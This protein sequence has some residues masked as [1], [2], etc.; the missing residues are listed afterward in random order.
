MSSKSIGA[1]FHDAAERARS[2][3]PKQDDQ[4]SMYGLYKQVTV[5]ECMTNKPSMFDIAGK[6]KWDAWMK[7]KGMSKDDAGTAYI[8]LVDRVAGVPSSLDAAGQDPAAAAP[9]S[10]APGAAATK[11]STP[12]AELVYTSSSSSPPPPPPPSSPPPASPSNSSAANNEG[13]TNEYGTGVP[14]LD[15]D[16]S[17]HIKTIEPT[18]EH[19]P[20]IAELRESLKKEEIYINNKF[21]CDR[22]CTDDALMRFLVAKGYKMHACSKLLKDAMIW[23][24][25][26]NVD[27]QEEEEGWQERFSKEGETG[28]IYNAGLDRWGRSL[29]VFDNTVQNTKVVDGQMKFLAWQLNLAC[30]TMAVETPLIADKYVVFMHLYDFSLFSA[31]SWAA[32]EETIHMLCNCFPERLGHCIAYNAPAM[33]RTFWNL[34]KGFIDPRTRAKLIFVTGDCSNGSDNDIY[35][36]RVIGDDWRDKCCVDKPLVRKGCSPGYDHDIAWPAFMERVKDLQSRENLISNDPE[37]AKHL[38][39]IEE[40][41]PEKASPRLPSV[42]QE[43]PPKSPFFSPFNW[44]KKKKSTPGTIEGKISMTLSSSPEQE[45]QEQEELDTIVG[46]VSVIGGDES[47]TTE[48]EESVES[49]ESEDNILSNANSP[50]YPLSSTAWTMVACNLLLFCL[51][52]LL[53]HRQIDTV[54]GVDPLLISIT[55]YCIQ[56]FGICIIAFD[57]PFLFLANLLSDKEEEER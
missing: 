43:T 15:F 5:G 34:C 41:S 7:C 46:N 45:E 51:T 30:R 55:I 6:A 9:A 29:V 23:R 19:L 53:R 35:M 20:L 48:S 3:Q 54:V 22:F 38:N 1:L 56:I 14:I 13:A 12:V 44:G 8:K 24:L 33:F 26:R 39:E 17:I 18:D 32:T 25:K 50:P 31:P 49:V 4:L 11:I 36:R 27:H 28:K 10:P 42:K 2:L 37:H 57:T 21:M 52:A 40:Q 47:G 16:Q